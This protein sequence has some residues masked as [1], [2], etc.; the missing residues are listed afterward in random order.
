M[1]LRNPVIS[2]RIDLWT[3]GTD[4]YGVPFVSKVAKPYYILYHALYNIC[5]I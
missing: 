4:A 5:I 1:F 2:S 3:F